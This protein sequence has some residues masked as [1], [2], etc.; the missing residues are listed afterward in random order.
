VSNKGSGLP[1]PNHSK[2]STS[3]AANKSAPSPLENKHGSK[4]KPQLSTPAKPNPYETMRNSNI[5]RNKEFLTNLNLKLAMETI[6][7]L[8]PLP[9]ST[10]KEKRLSAKP[11]YVPE[12]Q[13]R[14]ACSASKINSE[15]VSSS[16]SFSE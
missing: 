4:T 13:H 9:P 1:T 16:Y 14:C 3:M 11:A 6:L 10:T 2:P 7:P 15:R 5:V 12:D 8:L